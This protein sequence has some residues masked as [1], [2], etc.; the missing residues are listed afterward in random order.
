ME[1]NSNVGSDRIND[2]IM[3]LLSST[4]IIKSSGTDFFTSEA[5]L[6]FIQLRKRVIKVSIS[7]CFDLK[8]YIWM[9]INISDYVISRLLSQL[10][11]KKRLANQVTHKLN[12]NVLSKIG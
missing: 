2:R 1:D 12:D 6:A 8:D 3:N 10:I 5:C 9:N 11:I 7:H 4:K